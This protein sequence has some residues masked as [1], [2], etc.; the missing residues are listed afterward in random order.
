MALGDQGVKALR[1][2]NLTLTTP[3]AS[4]V[5][6]ATSPMSDSRSNLSPKTPSETLRTSPSMRLETPLKGL[7]DGKP[8]RK[9]LVNTS[10]EVEPELTILTKTSGCAEEKLSEKHVPQKQ[11]TQET[12]CRLF[13]LDLVFCWLWHAESLGLNSDHV[14]VCLDAAIALRRTFRAHRGFKLSHLPLNLVAEH[15]CHENVLAR[16]YALELLGEIG[17]FAGPFRD[18]ILTLVQDKDMMVRAKAIN[19]LARLPE[20]SRQSVDVMIKLLSDSEEIVARA[21]CAALNRCHAQLNA[22]DVCHVSSHLNS[23]SCDLRENVVRL[24]SN[25]GQL[26]QPHIGRM[27]TLSP[28]DGVPSALEKL[29][30]EGVHIPPQP[31]RRTRRR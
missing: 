19:A 25:L 26:A 22:S 12:D 27:L 31:R 24:L 29:R 18:Q 2:D 11:M 6:K 15:L 5:D 16:R 28:G 17:Y 1:P 20:C 23:R 21:S 3:Y 8:K 30:R 7:R 10:A 4:G 14:N 9:L 13:V